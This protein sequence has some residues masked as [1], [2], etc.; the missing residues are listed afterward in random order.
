MIT[1]IKRPMWLCLDCW[2]VVKLNVA[3]VSFFLSILLLRCKVLN[4][5]WGFLFNY[6]N[7]M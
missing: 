2:S 4:V 5:T 6:L 3:Y 1:D 7:F